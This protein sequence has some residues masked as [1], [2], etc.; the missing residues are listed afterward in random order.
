MTKEQLLKLAEFYQRTY[1]PTSRAVGEDKQ[2]VEVL[3]K[4]ARFVEA[5]TLSRLV[6]KLN[7]SEKCS[8]VGAGHCDCPLDPLKEELHALIFEAI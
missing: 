8:G 1:M 5:N 2:I 4:F 6:V 7:E 3:A